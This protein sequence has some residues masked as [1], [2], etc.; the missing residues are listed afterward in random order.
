MAQVPWHST[1]RVTD[2]PEIR[3]RGLLGPT[4]FAQA[5]IS[6]VLND[7]FEDAKALL[8]SPMMAVNYAHLVM[9]AARGIVSSAD[10]HAIRV[11]LDGVSLAEVRAVKY[12]GSYEDLF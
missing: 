9:L 6:C 1:H 8:L 7:N 12:D 5:Y 3:E 4:D 10:A 2:G 11:A